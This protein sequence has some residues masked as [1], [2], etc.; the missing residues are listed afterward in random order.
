M[1]PKPWSYL[2]GMLLVISTLCLMSCGHH[3]QE[4]K[5][6]FLP[7]GQVH[8]GWYFAAG[9]RVIIQG[10]VNGD[11]YVAGGIV[12][13]DGTINGDLLAAGGQVIVSGTVTNNI[14]AAGGT[15]RIDGNVGR[16]VTTAGGSIAVGKQSSVSGN[17]LAAGGDMTIS[18]NIGKEARLAGS[19]LTVLGSVNGPVAFSGG[20]L[21]IVPGAR[22]QKDLLVEVKDTSN[23]NIAPGVVQGTVT[24]HIKEK[25][26]ETRILGVSLFAFWFSFFWICSTLVTGLVLVL[27]FPA[28]VIGTASAIEQRPGVSAVTGLIGLVVIPFAVLLLMVTLVAIPLALFVI[29]VFFFLL[30]LSQLAL[31]VAVGD[32]IFHLEGKRAWRLFLPVAVGVLIVQLLA[33]VPFLKILII[34]AEFILGFGALLYMIWKEYN[35]RRIIPV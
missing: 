6:V 11:A 28:Q 29:A 8:D 24:R 31:G 2:G 9:Q 32:R 7:A 4:Q 21:D 26:E 10:T 5:Q 14:R 16:D 23:I 18:G 22:I 1:K 35:S 13:I 19:Q 17:L 25:P 20:K 30:Y 15:I 27:L 33:L 3:R 34:L 12:E